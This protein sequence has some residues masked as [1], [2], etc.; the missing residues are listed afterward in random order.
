MQARSGAHWFVR[1]R[2]ALGH[3]ARIIGPESVQPFRSSGKNDV[4]DAATGRVQMRAVGRLLQF[5]SQ[6]CPTWLSWRVSISRSSDCAGEADPG[7]AAAGAPPDP[8]RAAA[9][10][11]AAL[12]PA[13]ALVRRP[14]Q[15]QPA[16]DHS[17]Y[18]RNRGRLP[19]YAV[20][21]GFFAEV[22]RLDDRQ[23]L[24]SQEHVPVDGTLVQ[25]RRAGRAS[26]PW[27][28]ERPA[29]GWPRHDE[30]PRHGR[31]G[32]TGRRANPRQRTAA[33]AAA[34]ARWRGLSR[35]RRCGTD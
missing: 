6:R 14:G 12:Q 9:V 28:G 30:P 5:D 7:A 21:A 27:T 4:R 20:A 19:D 16:R 22:L 17:T 35:P 26:A 29:T 24:P 23:S 1:E 34:C 13:V 15:R 31:R 8:Q 18:S 3:T 11:A 10:R 2:C 32:P 33:T 25:G